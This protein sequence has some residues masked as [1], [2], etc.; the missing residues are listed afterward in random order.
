M[1]KICLTICSLFFIIGC[2]NPD[3]KVSNF[4]AN[5]STV[6]D[7][8]GMCDKTYLETLDSGVYLHQDNSKISLEVE[9]HVSCTVSYKLKLQ[10]GS[11]FGH[12][13]TIAD[14]NG[15]TVSVK[16]KICIPT[17][18]PPPP[19]DEPNHQCPPFCTD[20]EYSL[21]IV[22]SDEFYLSSSMSEIEGSYLKK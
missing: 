6:V 1:Q 12:D 22:S 21:E 8:S 17:P 20:L 7:E 4:N 5:S 9:K 14:Q 18:C 10:T 2:V 15:K 19:P 16:T 11:I 3:S 13:Q